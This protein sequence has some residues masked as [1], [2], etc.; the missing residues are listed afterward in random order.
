ML[1]SNRPDWDRVFRQVRGV[2]MFD[3]CFASAVT[4]MHYKGWLSFL[5][6][7]STPVSLI[8]AALG[9]VLG[10]RTNSAYSRWWEA[11]ILWGGLINSSRSLARQIL[12]FT[13][14]RHLAEKII[15]AQIALVHA[16]RCHLRGEDAGRELEGRLPED[17]IAALK[18][19][20]NIPVSLLN[21][22]GHWLA[23][24]AGEG[25]LTEL[26]LHRMDQTLSE[27]TN[28]LG[29][30]E[31][32]KNTP[33][34][35]QYHYF[36]ELFIYI[37]CLMF[38]LTVV[39]DVRLLTPLFSGAITF[40]FL[41]LNNIGKNLEDPFDSVR[42]GTPLRALSGAVERNLLQGLGNGGC[43]EVVMPRGGVLE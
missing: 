38:P 28:I 42:Y 40:V 20:Q 4:A 39:R 2:L 43:P 24:A 16:F 1:V 36:P 8:G 5:E 23:R 22:M 11:R 31:R 25:K 30:C 18:T 7:P 10:F 41:I 37:Y 15:L 21:L 32:I 27:I 34:P 9:I 33:F 29:G 14:D 3:I 35:R 17:A 19:T 12:A 6:V 13:P 26:Q